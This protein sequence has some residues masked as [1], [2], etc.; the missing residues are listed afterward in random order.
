MRRASAYCQYRQYERL[1]QAGQIAIVHT[2]TRRRYLR[3]SFVRDFMGKG[4]A[5]ETDHWRKSLLAVFGRYLAH[6]GIS[7]VTEVSRKIEVESLAVLKS[8]AFS[9]QEADRW[10]LPGSSHRPERLLQAAGGTREAPG[11]PTSPAPY[12]EAAT[13]QSCVSSRSAYPKHMN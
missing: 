6:N 9:A 11:E 5:Q 7:N 13:G 8:A 12:P 2:P 3:S 4:Y 10:Y 1:Q